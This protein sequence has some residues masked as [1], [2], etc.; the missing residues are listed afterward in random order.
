MF[1]SRFRTVEP[2]EAA[3]SLADVKSYLYVTDSDTDDLITQQIS[4]A[5][6]WVEDNGNIALITQTLR[7]SFYEIGADRT[8]ILPSPPLQSVTTLEYL[9]ENATWQTLASGKYDLEADR[10]PGR[11]KIRSGEVPTVHA[12]I[13]PKWR[14]TY[15]AGYAADAATFKT[16]QPALHSL[17]QKLVRD[18]NEGCGLPEGKAAKTILDLYRVQPISLGAA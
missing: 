9:D 1:V 12:T 10:K 5:V 4:A 6:Q 17:I 11:A 3:V 15:V 7:A 8:F 18:I 13:S 2:A 14:I 16:K